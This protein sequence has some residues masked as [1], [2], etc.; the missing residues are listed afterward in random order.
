MPLFCR[1]S[2]I[3]TLAVWW[4]CRL[5]SKGSRM[6]NQ[7]LP[8]WLP[9]LSDSS[10]L[11]WLQC[12]QTATGPESPEGRHTGVFSDTQRNVDVFSKGKNKIG[13]FWGPSNM[14]PHDQWRIYHP[15]K[16]ERDVGRCWSGRSCR[17]L[18]GWTQRRGRKHEG[19]CTSGQIWSAALGKPNLM[20]SSGGQ[21]G[22]HCSA[23][24]SSCSMILWRSLRTSRGKS[25]GF[26]FTWLSGQ[27]TLLSL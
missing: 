2:E 15:R 11:S 14:L 8:V 4:S 3:L 25:G 24:F 10:R 9:A 22:G 18:L 13:A 1:N 19:N 12:S 20:G 16:W 27:I 26:S 7:S 23:C 17:S 6:G 5:D 21:A